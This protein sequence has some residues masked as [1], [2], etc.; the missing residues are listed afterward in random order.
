MLFPNAFILLAYTTRIKSCTDRVRRDVN[1]LL[2]AVLNELWLKQPWVTFD[3]VGRRCDPRAVN[4]SLQVLLCVV[5]D[6]DG[7]RLLLGQ[8]CH[9]P[10][11]VDNGHIV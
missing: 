4:Q 11:C 6:T 9:S 8:L 2:F 7:T 1:V 10:P 5:G 3:L